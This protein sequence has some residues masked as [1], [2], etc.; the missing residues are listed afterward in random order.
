MSEWTEAHNNVYGENGKL[1]ALCEAGGKAE[2]IVREHN[3]HVKFVGLMRE[4]RN[5]CSKNIE[6]YT[7]K[8]PLLKDVLEYLPDHDPI[9]TEKYFQGIIDHI[10]AALALAEGREE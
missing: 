5:S 9:K 1:V 6:W 10:D 8:D 7:G 2:Q 3:A 4:W